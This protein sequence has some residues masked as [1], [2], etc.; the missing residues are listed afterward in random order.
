MFCNILYPN[1]RIILTYFSPS[2]S[3]NCDV[4]EALVSGDQYNVPDDKV[5][6]SSSHND[7]PRYETFRLNAGGG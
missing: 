5:S 6:F 2:I 1:I 3:A 4:P 7:D